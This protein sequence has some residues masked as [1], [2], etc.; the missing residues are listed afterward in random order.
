MRL[1]SFGQQEMCATAGLD[2]T[3]AS[4]YTNRATMAMVYGAAEVFML[5]DRSP[6][7]ADT[8]AFVRRRVSDA[9][10]TLSPDSASRVDAALESLK[11]C[12]FP[13]RAAGPAGAATAAATANTTFAESSS[14]PSQNASS[15]G[16][17]T[18][19]SPLGG[20]AGSWGSTPNTTATAVSA[21]ASVAAEVAFGAFST[22]LPKGEPLHRNDR[23][24]DNTR[25]KSFA[26]GPEDEPASATESAAFAPPKE[27]TNEADPVGLVK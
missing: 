26:P 23:F 14:R 11:S 6:A 7:F 3:D 25:V 21:L 15:H 16:A 24:S 10:A 5:Q 13:S 4:W 22:L 17:A 9:F 12:V 18:F 19:A 27:Q 8:R 20:G 1:H 2:A